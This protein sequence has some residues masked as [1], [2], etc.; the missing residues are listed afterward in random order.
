[1]HFVFNIFYEFLFLLFKLHALQSVNFVAA[2]DCPLRALVDDELRERVAA[3]KMQKLQCKYE[4][5][6][7]RPAPRSSSPRHRHHC[8]RRLRRR[9]R[10]LCCCCRG[11]RRVRSNWPPL[12]ARSHF[13]VV[14]DAT[15]TRALRPSS[16]FSLAVARRPTTRPAS[17]KASARP[18]GLSPFCRLASAR[19]IA[20]AARRSAALLSGRPAAARRSSHLRAVAVS[21]WPTR[22]RRRRC[23]RRRPGGEL[24][25]VSTSRRCRSID[26]GRGM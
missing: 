10:R 22:R 8:R 21:R 5:A 7:E 3:S 4:S 2:H 11:A 19:V 25:A 17:E 16:S 20:A 13:I 9:R 24:S 23:Q 15:A 1:M 26:R 6:R 14:G 18:P 12:V